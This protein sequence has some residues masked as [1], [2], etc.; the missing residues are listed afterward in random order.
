[1]ADIMV[2]VNRRYLDPMR[3]MF[4]SLFTNNPDPIRLFVFHAELEEDEIGE[5]RMFLEQYKNVTFVPI[6]LD[7][8]CVD[9]LPVSDVLPAEV[10]YK[11]VALDE[12]PEDVHQILCMDLDMIVK[13][14][15][16]ELL[17]LRLPKDCPLAATQ[18]L[19]GDLFGETPKNN[20]RL[21]LP[22]NNKYFNAG[23]LL[24]NL[25]HIR[26]LPKK[27]GRSVL[28]TW[29]FEHSDLLKWREQDVFNGVFFGKYVSLPWALYNCPPVMFVMKQEEVNR[30]ILR[31][32]TREEANSMENLDG[33]ADYTQAIA[34]QAVIIHYIGETK[35]W[36]KERPDTATFRF[37]DSYYRS[38]EED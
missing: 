34:E 30:G 21:G 27:D 33:Y 25:D 22:K 6:R 37:F 35:P 17:E 13:G 24:F 18:D 15:L 31:P 8:S 38:W 11:L 2:M 4:R 1:M 23:L 26:K 16:K 28:L 9:G 7:Q 32:L 36:N 20:E 3:V 29:A 10:Y 5:I 14:S 12:L 19:Y